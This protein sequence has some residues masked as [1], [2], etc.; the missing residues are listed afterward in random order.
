MQICLRIQRQSSEGAPQFEP[1]FL[2][3]SPRITILDCLNQIKW[4]QDG[5]LAFRKNCRNT[6][7]GSCAVRINGR[8]DLACKQTLQDELDR[9]ANVQS[10][11]GSPSSNE[12]PTIE[13]SPLQNFPVIKD[14][15]VD[16]E[17][18]WQN[19]EQVDPYVSTA[20][21]TV[22]ERE[23]LQLPSERATLDQVGNCILCGACYS[24]CNAK[25]VTPEFVGP[26]ALAKAYRI[27]AD[28][29]SADGAERLQKS[30]QDL[31]GVWGCTRCFNCNSSCPMDVAPLDQITRIK[32]M[33]LVQ[34]S[35][36][37]LRAI[38]HRETM[39]DLV[40]ESGW[41]DERQ[42]GLR[43]LGNRFRDLKGLMSLVPL[44]LRMLVR[45]KFPM[46]FN[47]SE[48]T[49]TVRAIIHGLKMRKSGS[50]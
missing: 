36:P 1:F 11:L 43:V 2:E 27:L 24:E 32:T 22:P 25:T 12:Y 37:E 39:I 6:I 10:Y 28:N 30:A 42:F 5:S 23:F 9:M 14:L 18:F 29:R 8:A 38:R 45:R 16:M 46:T 47:A 40:A 15:V 21:R 20:G 31:S 17:Q 48:G 44:G 34:P 13:I 3:V 33:A 49:R 35:N 26:H 7:C 4:E 41:I 19:L 50:K